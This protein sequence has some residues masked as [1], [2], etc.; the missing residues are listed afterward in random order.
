MKLDL[1]A[2]QDACSD[3]I[4]RDDHAALIKSISHIYQDKDISLAHTKNEW[5]RV[6]GLIDGQGNKVADQLRAWV[7]AQDV[8]DVLGLYELYGDENLLVTRIVGKTM[9]FVIPVG[10]DPLNY[11]QLEVDEIKEVVDRHLFDDENLADDFEDLIDPMEYQRAVPKQIA[12]PHYSFRNARHMYDVKNTMLADTP[13]KRFYEEWK[14]SS[15]MDM[16]HFSDFWVLNFAKHKGAFGE[17]RT[18]IKPVSRQKEKAPEVDI[19]KL[20]RGQPLARIIHGFDRSIGYP[21]AWY[22]FMLTSQ[23]NFHKLAETV[24]DDLMGAYAYL[25]AKDLKILKSWIADP[26]CFY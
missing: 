9:Y 12:L 17:V 4:V 22:F 23:K 20:E 13:F 14:A 3:T 21:M 25:P 8:D 1:K 18:D 2:L 6:G 10:D 16:G 19:T 11:I 26:Y 5:Y 15:A 7:E 24:H